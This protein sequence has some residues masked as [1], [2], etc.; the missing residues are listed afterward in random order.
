MKHITINELIK[1]T[2]AKIVDVRE[3]DEYL[4]G[5]V[6]NAVNVPMSGL[7]FNADQFLSKNE[8]YYIICQSGGRSQMTVE[9]LTKQGYNV[10][11]VLGGTNAYNNL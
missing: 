3:K 4:T 10:T 8:H 6:P 11:N 2:D 1:L 7:M 9:N 5:H